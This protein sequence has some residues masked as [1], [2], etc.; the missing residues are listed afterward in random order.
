MDVEITPEPGPEERMAIELAVRRLVA[1]PV[2]PTA[3][4]SAWRKAGLPDAAD[5]D[6]DYPRTAKSS[7][8]PGTPLSS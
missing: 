8:V 1:R 6:E 2:L 3:Y 5:V 7:H 4:A